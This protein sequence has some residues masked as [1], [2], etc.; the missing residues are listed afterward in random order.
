VRS[1]AMVK[2]DV[3]L[4]DGGSA[5]LPSIQDFFGSVPERPAA[6]VK[7]SA[8]VKKVRGAAGGAPDAAGRGQVAKPH[9]KAAKRQ[10]SSPA[11]ADNASVGSGSPG[12]T[13]G[14]AESSAE[15]EDKMERTVFVGG[16]PL[17]DEGRLINP[18]TIKGFFRDCGEVE[19]VRLRSLPVENP[20]LPKKAA[21][22]MGKINGKRETCNAYVVFK[23]KDSVAAALRKDGASFGDEGYRIRVDGAKPPGEG[24]KTHNVRLSV[25]VGNV[26]FNAEEEALRSHF[27]QCGEITNVRV[28][29][30][31]K[32]LVGK[33]FA[34]VTFTD[35]DAVSSAMRLSGS[36]L[37]K[38]ELR[39]VRCSKK[40]SSAQIGGAGSV[41][42][43]RVA[44]KGGQ[45]R[46]GAEYRR[47]MQR[48]QKRTE[49]DAGGGKGGKEGVGKGG[50]KSKEAK[51][52]KKERYLKIQKAPKF[53][54]RKRDK[55][56]NNG[57]KG[58]AV[59]KGEKRKGKDKKNM[60]RAKKMLKGKKRKV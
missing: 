16:V 6:A 11:P 13:I 9:D 55:K 24:G 18:K 26:P 8:A 31:P 29:R 28:V 59:T 23:S 36:K 10:R 44:K 22:A 1:G 52:K 57:I 27:N 4:E 2:L 38:R 46:M 30:D 39:V 19:S 43:G 5:T 60:K 14:I 48:D 49:G 54:D 12:K 42:S 7:K 34:Y 32:T 51:L 21:I 53:K 15:S 3:G 41:Q 17:A 50:P 25:F 33:G 45:N 40:P 35:C 56:A 37:L 47:R 58:S 20:V